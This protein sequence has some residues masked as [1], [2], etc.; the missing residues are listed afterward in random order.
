MK[1]IVCKKE[2]TELEQETS[3]TCFDC[4]KKPTHMTLWAVK[5]INPIHPVTEEKWKYNDTKLYWNE[6]GAKRAR[7]YHEKRRL[8]GIAH[9]QMILDSGKHP[10]PEWLR[11]NIFKNT[12]LSYKVVELKL[13]EL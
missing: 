3:E 1:C 10:D 4:M 12:K 7:A 11:R 8:Q 13:E 6:G 9:N 5:I 2:L